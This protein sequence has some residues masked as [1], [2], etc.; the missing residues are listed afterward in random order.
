VGDELGTELVGR[1]A[2]V[3]GGGTGIGAACVRAL[4]AAGAS[5]VAL[6]RRPEPLE[7][8]VAELAGGADADVAAFPA[9]VTQPEQIAAAVKF[10]TAT[11]GAPEIVV[12]AA[13]VAHAGPLGA[14]TDEDFD[15]VLDVNLR[16]VWHV[17]RAVVPAMKRAGY[18][19][20]VNVASTAG[21]R[22]YRF[23]AAY[24]ASKHAL[25]GLSRT[26]AAELLPHGITVNSV[27]PGFAD[28]EIVESAARKIADKTGKTLDAAKA[29][30]AAQ[31][32]LG[33]LVTPDEVAAAAL[34]FASRSAAAASGTTLVLDGGTPYYG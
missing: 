8:L 20:I 11:F 7:R 33:R 32:P 26:L 28:T 10:A 12:N 2:L 4:C 9:D 30:L 16:G 23:N 17:V 21:L 19:R 34:Y 13:G 29:A 6:G 25:L 3:T 5:V 18:G 31:N 24:V 22:G 15:R 14:T 1:R 27:C